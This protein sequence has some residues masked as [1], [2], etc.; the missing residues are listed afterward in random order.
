VK[1]Q[2]WEKT[3]SKTRTIGKL[4]LHYGLIGPEDLEEGLAWQKKTGL[5]LGESLAQLGKIT[6]EDIEWVLS[7]QL[8][9]PFVIVEDLDVSYDLVRRFDKGFL[10]ENRL[11]PVYET[12]DHVAVVTD[13]PFNETAIGFLKKI[14]DKEVHLSTG[15]G[16][17]I[18][19]RLTSFYKKH[20]LPD[21]VACVEDILARI[22]T[23]FFYR[24]DFL[25]REQSCSVNVFGFDISKQ[26][27][28]L[29]GRFN[30]EDVCQAFESQ[31]I[32]FLYEVLTNSRETI[33]TIVPVVRRIDEFYMPA[34]LGCYGLMLPPGPVVTD[35]LSWGLLNVFH[36]NRPV[37]GYPWFTTWNSGVEHQGMIYTVDAAPVTFVDHYVNVRIPVACSSC[38]GSGCPSCKNL[39]YVCRAVEGI[40]SS[41]ELKEL[42]AEE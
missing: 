25:L 38:L 39:G 2:I 34:I 7:K 12:D 8:D 10:L 35:S 14:V 11:L 29:Q 1:P 28:T 21:L 23:T 31:N 30:K 27:S 6:M 20:G 42:M 16:D 41:D 19:A 4:L 13:D 37:S 15:N 26:I 5:R 32:P 24:L 18:K 33:L 17:K 40:Y 36:S 22:E 3:V 9:I